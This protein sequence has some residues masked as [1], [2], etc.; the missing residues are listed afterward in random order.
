MKDTLSDWFDS[1]IDRQSVIIAVIISIA[2]S[3][4]IVGFDVIVNPINRSVT[5][6]FG[7]V[8]A[9]ALFFALRGNIIPGKWVVPFAGYLLVSL[10]VYRGGIRDGSILAY[11]LVILIAGLFLGQG[12][13]LTIGALSA[14]TA[15]AI[16][17]AEANGWLLNYMSLYVTVPDAIAVGVLLTGLTGLQVLILG[18]SKKFLHDAQQLTLAEQAANLELKNLQETLETRITERTADLERTARAMEHRVNQLQAISEIARSIANT[19]DLSELLPRIADVIS[20]FFGFYHV[21]IFLLDEKKEYAEL[22]AASSEGGKRMLARSH[23]LR[24]GYQG[25]VGFAARQGRARIALDTGED[26]VFFDNPDLPTTRS[27]AALPL[28]LGDEVI[29]VL[30]VQSEIPEAFS[31]DDI[32][33]FNTLAFQVSIAI[34]NASLLSR[35]HTALQEAQRIS[36][37]QTRASWSNVGEGG[38]KLGYQF[39]GKTNDPIFQPVDTPEVGQALATGTQQQTDRTLAIPIK[40]R[41]ETIGVIGV[42]AKSDRRVWSPG[43][44]NIA[45]AAAERA[46]LALENARLVEEAQ[47]RAALERMTTEITGK[48]GTSVQYRSIM[49]IA[50]EELSRALGTEVL[51]QIQPEI[52]KPTIEK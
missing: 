6:G 52:Q 45:R 1:Q 7:I 34:Q 29:G 8:S 33:V 17:V 38:Q 24:V 9:V 11:P 44:I 20:E 16:G 14:I 23:R 49:R 12:G 37:E 22:R 48:I 15:T 30:D 5:I 26:A 2:L 42:K 51:V 35:A 43:E 19:Q 39:D 47:R 50:A 13:T 31:D 27:E 18:R 40:L 28:M 32:E 3:A 41:G 36:R 25:V 46:A 21:G 4:G 10:L